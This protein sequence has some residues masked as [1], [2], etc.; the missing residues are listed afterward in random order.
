MSKK[1]LIFVPVR[2]LNEIL[3]KT[4]DKIPKKFRD[5]I[6]LILIN[7]NNSD[8]ET[9]KIIN[10]YT[11]KNRFNIK[12]NFFTKNIGFGGSKKNAYNYA[13]DNNYDYVICL[14]GDGQYPPEKL[15]IIYNFLS[16]EGYDMVQGS[17]VNYIKGGMPFYKIFANKVLNF[18]E[19]LVFKFE[20]LEYHSGYRGYSCKALKKIPLDKLSNSHLITAEILAIAKIKNFKVKDFPIDTIYDGD[21]SSMKF[22][23]ALK[24]GINVFYVLIN[25]FL[26]KYNLNFDPLYNKYNRDND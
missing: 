5:K 18:L 7:D 21:S 19:N 3:S 6:S 24:Y 14:H 2:N 10:K 13:I 4:L 26:S 15:E 16:N 17:R 12:V 20:F 11:D 1:L 23:P 25:C 9:K 8:L 22:L